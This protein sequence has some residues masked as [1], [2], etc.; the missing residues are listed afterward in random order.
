M[1]DDTSLKTSARTGSP[2]MTSSAVLA[3]LLT[4]ALSL[5]GLASPAQAVTPVR[6]K[7]YHGAFQKN[8]IVAD[9]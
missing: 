7:G 5:L 6:A 2:R 8:D 9:P 3:S 1:K 4:L